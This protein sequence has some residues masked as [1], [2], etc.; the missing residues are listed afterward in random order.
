MRWLTVGLAALV[1]LPLLLLAAG[2]VG[3][4]AGQAPGDLGVQDG[5]LKAPSRTPNSVSSQAGL[6]PGLSNREAATI[7]P[8]ALVGGDGPATIEQLQALVVQWPGATVVTA[9]PDYLYATF[10]SRWLGFVDDV[11]FW[12]DPAQQV[13]QVRSAS[14]IGQSDLGANRARVERIRAQ[15]AAR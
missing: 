5:R 9:R 8:L 7:T 13:V 12:F 4:L 15:L 1:G 3:L 10:R 6:W 2:Q 14:R 11:E